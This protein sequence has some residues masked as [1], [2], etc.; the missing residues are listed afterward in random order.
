MLRALSVF[1]MMQETA[2]FRYRGLPDICSHGGNEDSVL[3]DALYREV[4]GVFLKRIEA[5]AGASR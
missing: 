5:Q 2:S 4:T 1:L 3:K